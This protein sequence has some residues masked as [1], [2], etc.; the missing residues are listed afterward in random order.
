MASSN[1]MRFIHF[2]NS[3]RKA[4]LLPAAAMD[5]AAKL[6]A[7]KKALL[8]VARTIVGTDESDDD[9]LIFETVS[10]IGG[11]KCFDEVDIDVL[12]WC[13]QPDGLRVSLREIKV[14]GAK[15]KTTRKPKKKIAGRNEAILCFRQ[16]C[17]R[18]KPDVTHP[19]NMDHVGRDEAGRNVYVFKHKQH[20]YNSNDGTGLMTDAFFAMK[21]TIKDQA[22]QEMTSTSMHLLSLTGNL[23]KT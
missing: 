18:K 15:S 5:C 11:N 14:E 2:E 6:E 7:S 8:K 10:V 20:Y 9:E 22:V 1:L 21:A 19:P 16:M 17:L 12:L 3:D 23:F 13:D 4:V